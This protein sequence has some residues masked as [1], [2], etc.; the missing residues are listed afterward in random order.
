M[1]SLGWSQSGWLLS[2][3]YFDQMKKAD[4]ALWARLAALALEKEKAHAKT[5]A[6]PEL[7]ERILIQVLS[8]Q[9]LRQQKS[10]QPI[11]M[12]LTRSTRE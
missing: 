11:V 10:N 1:Y 5:L 9:R 8:D 7:R 4:A 6:S 12:Y 2:D 3:P